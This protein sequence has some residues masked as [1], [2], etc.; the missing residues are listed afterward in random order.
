RQ[1]RGARLRP[2]DRGRS[3]RRGAAG[4]SGH[5]GVPGEPGMSAST[6]PEAAATVGTDHRP[7]LAVEDLH[8]RYGAVRELHGLTFHIEHGEI[9]V[10]LG[11]NGAGKTTT[12][13]AICGM[14][15][16]HGSVR[17]EGRQLVGRRPDRIAR[18]GVAHVPQGRGTFP[19]LS[20]HE[21]L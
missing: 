6:A 8:A 20:V 16:T 10:I 15:S 5:R 14:V 7:L 17:L 11:A 4:P 19:E 12:M 18:L 9:V 1:G 2:E 13:R 21:N 3:P